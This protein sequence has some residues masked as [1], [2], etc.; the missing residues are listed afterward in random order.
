MFEKIKVHFND[1][2]QIITKSIANVQLACGS[3]PIQIINK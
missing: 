2:Y 3:K 1:Y